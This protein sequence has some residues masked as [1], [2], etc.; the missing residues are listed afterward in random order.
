[1][2]HLDT[3]ILIAMVKV[4]DEHHPAARKLAATPHQFSTSAV[5]WMEFH[6]RPV[7]PTLTMALR[8][9]LSGGIVPFDD[10]TAALAGDLYHRVRSSRRTRMDVMIAATAILAGAELATV[11]PNDFQAFLPHGLILCPI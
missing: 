8:G 4:A 6:S 2:I 3:S 7:Q 1:M 9:L 5:A 10:Q 11:N